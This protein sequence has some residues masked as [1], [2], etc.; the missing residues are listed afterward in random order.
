M[1]TVYAIGAVITAVVSLS[2]VL[3]QDDVLANFSMVRLLIA[4]VFWP[5]F[6]AA[7]TIAL[8]VMTLKRNK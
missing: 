7:F 8:L 1:I 3:L 2:I 4:I 6:W 5:I